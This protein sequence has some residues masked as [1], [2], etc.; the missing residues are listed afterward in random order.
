MSPPPPGFYPAARVNTKMVDALL[1][2]AEVRINI[3]AA[4]QNDRVAEI[5]LGL[6]VVSSAVV[7]RCGATPSAFSSSIVTDAGGAGAPAIGSPRR[8]PTDTQQACHY[9]RRVVCVHRPC[10]R[11]VDRALGTTISSRN[12]TSRRVFGKAARTSQD[13]R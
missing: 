4:E 11:R 5:V 1:D 2:E 7:N 12:R 13:G 10:R 3:V 8:V 6:A 9:A